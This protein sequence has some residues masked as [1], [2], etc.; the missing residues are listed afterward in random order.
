MATVALPL[1]ASAETRV[2][3]SGPGG[4][5]LQEAEMPLPPQ[6]EGGISP[7][8]REDDAEFTPQIMSLYLKEYKC[9]LPTTQVT[10][11]ESY[12]KSAQ[13][14]PDFAEQHRSQELF[15]ISGHSAA[16]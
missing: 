3:H 16:F 1:R 15:L 11:L 12:Q 14:K 2:S 6:S 9:L 5:F 7:N 4:G 8:F 10:T 13:I